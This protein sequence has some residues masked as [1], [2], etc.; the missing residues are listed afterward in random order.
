VSFNAVPG[1]K[2]IAGQVFGDCRSWICD[3]AGGIDL[4]V[5]SEDFPHLPDPCFI[6]TCN[7]W[8]PLRTPNFHAP[9]LTSK[10][11]GGFCDDKGTCLQCVLDADCPG[12]GQRCKA[13]ICVSCGDGIQ[14]GDET[15]VD[16]GGSCGACLSAPC[17]GDQECATGN[18]GF[19]NAQAPK[20]E[21]VCCDAP[22]DEVCFQCS[23]AGFCGWVPTGSP[24][25]DT[26]NSPYEA[27]KTGSCKIKTN[28]PCVQNS[29]CISGSCVSGTCK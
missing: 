13:N 17:T 12:V 16:C 8:T 11:T 3:G 29:D 9:C 6:W 28:Y 14:N 15:G 23:T 27:C 25:V 7:G 2:L 22:C 19:T 21:K 1:T 10:G 24:D 26:C 20:P 4:Q 18:C 5:D